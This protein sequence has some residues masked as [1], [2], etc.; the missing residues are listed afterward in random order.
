MLAYNPNTPVLFMVFKYSIKMMQV[1][2][3]VRNAKPKKLYIAFEAMPFQ[4]QGENQ[5]HQEANRILS[6]VDWDCEIQTLFLEDYT[7][8]F[9]NPVSWFFSHE[10][11]GII[12]NDRNLPDDIFF[13]FC[14]ELLE[15]YRNDTRIG[16]ISGTNYTTSKNHL[17]SYYFSSLVNVSC[18]ATWK[19]VWQTVDMGLSTVDYFVE[20]N[21]I[22]SSPTYTK[23]K[24]E[25]LMRL[26]DYTPQQ[27]TNAWDIP[28]TYN[29]IVNNYLSIVPTVNL[30]KQI[31]N[32]VGAEKIMLNAPLQV[33]TELHH[34][35]FVLCNVSADW[36]EQ[37]T[38]QKAKNKGKLR[39]GLKDGYDF[40]KDRFV[41]LSGQNTNMRIPRIIHQIYED[42]VGPSDSLLELAKTWKE[43]HPA[44][45]YR[46]WSKK[47]MESFLTAEF[48]DFIPVYRDFPFNVQ[49]WDAIRYLIL[50]KIGGLYVDFDYGCLEPLDVL[51]NDTLCCMGMEPTLNAITH[52][53]S[54]IVG[55][56]LMASVPD[57]PYFELII[58][59]MM[60]GGKYSTL[61]DALRI[62]ET[63]G[64]FMTT[65]LYEQYPNKDEI[66]LLPA[67]LVAPFTLFEIRDLTRGLATPYILNKVE[68]CFAIH[69][70]GGSWYDQ[71]NLTQ[72]LK[73]AI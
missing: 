46:F 24:E 27:D 16:H 11:E 26:V 42:P 55:N 10:E 56:A 28:Y 25:W 19:R 51:L 48:P 58:K 59:E 57:H 62:M 37:E 71:I 13:G 7:E 47:E 68:K 61:P 31:D 2:E 67:D 36:E 69:Y 29:N 50:Y 3:K 30:V 5:Q 43:C 53:K 1:F 20:S 65:R 33:I 17:H 60:N 23:Y 41:T 70:F 4:L 21:I 9:N 38:L 73:G 22:E 18:W 39:E 14:S 15:K 63:T 49:R 52:N 44:W 34:P 6:Q 54:L 8:K 35:S 66:T 45:E 40:I 64:P 32:D 72:G 12:L